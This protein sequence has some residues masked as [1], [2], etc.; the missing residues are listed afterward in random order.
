MHLLLDAYA[1]GDFRLS[2]DMPD[3]L[4]LGVGNPLRGDD[5]VGLAVVD[6]LQER[7][8]PPGVVA[9][10]GGTAG[11]ELVLILANYRR[12][13]IV[14]AVDMGRAP[15]TWVCFAPN[16]A[17]VTVCR[18]ITS[19]HFAGLAEALELGAALG[20]LPEEVVIFGVQP[21]RLDRPLRLSAEVEAAVPAVGHA[22]LQEIGGHN[23]KNPD[24]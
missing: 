13:L 11:L 16:Q 6:W 5:G 24:S 12:A 9:V 20:V 10:D 3:T 15:G 23:G 4:L 1:R 19:L 18:S 8:L 7:G 2:D 14:D 22:L 21:A 17:Q